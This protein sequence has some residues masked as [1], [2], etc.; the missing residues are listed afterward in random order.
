VKT[1][2]W[3]GIQPV[4][5]RPMTPI[6]KHNLSVRVRNQRVHKRHPR[7]TRPHN[8]IVRLQL[9]HSTAAYVSLWECPM[10][11]GRRLL[12]CAACSG[13]S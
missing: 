11:R 12:V 5:T 9:A 6:D 2:E 8:E 13:F 10:S 1:N 7:R 4:A 3:I